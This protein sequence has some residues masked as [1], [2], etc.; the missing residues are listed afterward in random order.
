[1][2]SEQASRLPAPACGGSGSLAMRADVRCVPRVTSRHAIRTI[3]C[4]FTALGT[5]HLHDVAICGEV[6]HSAVDA[7][8]RSRPSA[9]PHPWRSFACTGRADNSFV[10]FCPLSVFHQEGRVESTMLSAHLGHEGWPTSPSL[11]PS[12]AQPSTFSCAAKPP[13]ERM[14]TLYGLGGQPNRPNDG[15]SDAS[16]EPSAL[17]RFAQ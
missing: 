7:L 13:C 5:N 11:W 14:R 10:C 6:T 1:V 15:Q 9:A 16:G 17:E 8:V 4:R 3:G 12:A 2:R